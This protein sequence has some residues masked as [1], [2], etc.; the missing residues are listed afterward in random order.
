MM[1][2]ITTSTISYTLNPSCLTT[3]YFP[4]KPNPAQILPNHME[5]CGQFLVTP[6]PPQTSTPVCEERKERGRE[7]GL[8]TYSP[9]R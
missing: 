4:N 3:P 5:L 7:D 1:L 9:S 2:I 8:Y 6:R